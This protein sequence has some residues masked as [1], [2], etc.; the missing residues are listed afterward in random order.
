MF[1]YQGDHL[2]IFQ[3]ST[4]K[5]HEHCSESAGA[6]TFY[7][8]FQIQSAPFGPRLLGCSFNHLESNC[9]TLILE[10]LSKQMQI[11]C[12]PITVQCKIQLKHRFFSEEY[13][14][15]LKSSSLCKPVQ[16]PFHTTPETSTPVPT[17]SAAFR[18]SLEGPSSKMAHHLIVVEC[19]SIW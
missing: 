10:R 18:F 11:L 5:Y 16:W 6:C 7:F 3:L 15:S 8:K 12:I 9:V 4:T 19:F 2:S 13:V 17:S 14:T 1:S